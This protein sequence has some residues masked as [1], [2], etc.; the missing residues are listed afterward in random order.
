MQMLHVSPKDIGTA[1]RTIRKEKGL[2]QKE[3]GQR[4]GLDQ[5]KVSL[6]ENGNPNV[7]VDSLFRLF[8]ALELGII[9]QP[10]ALPKPSNQNDW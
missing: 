9:L 8:S 6:I 4:I 5:K 10:K 2:S 3:L 1:L 7:R